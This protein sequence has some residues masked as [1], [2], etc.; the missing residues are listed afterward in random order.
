MPAHYDDTGLISLMNLPKRLAGTLTV[1]QTCSTTI[2]WS[3]AS[4]N[5][6]VWR[7][8]RYS[9]CLILSLDRIASEQSDAQ[10]WSKEQKKLP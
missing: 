6:R 10:R 7:Q 1:W 2:V 4:T 9:R 5:I 8:R 3:F